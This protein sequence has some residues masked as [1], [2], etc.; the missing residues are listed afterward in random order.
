MKF[1]KALIRQREF[2]IV[3]VIL[4]ISVVMSFVSPVFLTAGNI[5][6]LLMGLSTETIIAVAMTILMVSGG[7]D[8]SVGS[9]MGFSAVVCGVL[10]KQSSWPIVPAILVGLLVGTCIG[11]LNGLIVCKVGISAFITTL[12]GLNMYRGL[13]YVIT[14]GYHQSGLGDA[15]NAIGQGTLFSL[16]YPIYYAIILVIIGDILLRNSKFFRQSFYIGSNP[17]AARVSGINVDR[18]MIFNYALTGFMAALAGIIYAARCGSASVT[19]GSGLEVR[20][21]T[22]TIIGGASMSGGEGSVVGAFFGAL[23]TSLI[24]N[25]L[26]LLSIDVNWQQFV[27]GATLLIA[28]MI[29]T[30]NNKSKMNQMKK[31]S[32]RAK[33]E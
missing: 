8:M 15:F 1:Y 33:T 21:I 11:L 23:L 22:A 3:A 20:V 5:R 25:C 28:V 2:A 4:V 24:M 12:S 14:K 13:T 17:N 26:T 31:Q 18:I 9:V 10:I 6:A 7:I 19:A 16:Q 30:L 29:D 27:V 32:R